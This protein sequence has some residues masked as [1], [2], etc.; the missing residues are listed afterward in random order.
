MRLVQNIKI[1]L[2]AILTI[3]ALAMLGNN[4]ISWAK[5]I[6]AKIGLASDATTSWASV[7]ENPYNSLAAQL[8]NK[9]LTLEER[10][11]LLNRKEAEIL[12]ANA[13]QKNIV[14]IMAGG[15]MFLFCLILF[16]YY[17]D[18]RRKKNA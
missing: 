4:P 18:Y 16:N 9:E 17:F 2:L 6:S 11:D 8:R 1:F 5:L 3:S 13:G 10:E 14:I 7:G 12:N 15:I